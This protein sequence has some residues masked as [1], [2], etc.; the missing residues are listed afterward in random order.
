ML[1]KK[2]GQRFVVE[3]PKGL[4]TLSGDHI[5]L[6]P[7]PLDGDRAWAWAKSARTNSEKATRD[8]E[9]PDY[10]FERFVS[11][12]RLGDGTRMLLVRFLRYSPR[13][14][15]WKKCASLPS[16]TV[17]PHCKYCK[18]T[19]VVIRDLSPSGVYFCSTTRELVTLPR[20]RAAQ[21]K[22]RREK[23]EK[24]KVLRERYPR[25][26]FMGPRFQLTGSPSRDHLHEPH[27]HGR[28]LHRSRSQK[29]P[30]RR[31]G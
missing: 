23:Y 28:D 8:L 20:E 13:E 1:L 16:E 24:H 15:S 31:E 2:E 5:T 14:D 27:P 10:V 18:R 17:L 7:P 21:A 19:G 6:A 9:R 26:P 4:M 12:M 22:N 3:S 11:R 25:G 30:I 29:G